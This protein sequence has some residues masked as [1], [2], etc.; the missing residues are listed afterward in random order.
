[1]VYY[2]FAVYKAVY[3]PSNWAIRKKTERQQAKKEKKT[4][5]DGG[6]NLFSIHNI[7][8]LE[9]YLIIYELQAVSILKPSEVSKA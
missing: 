1:M 6:A 5:H 3:L 4:P 2:T 9:V 8:I 7:L